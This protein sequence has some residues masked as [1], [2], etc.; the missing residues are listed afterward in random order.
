MKLD[1]SSTAAFTRIDG[2]CD[3]QWLTLTMYYYSD[4]ASGDLQSFPESE[5]R[6]KLW[7]ND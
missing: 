5:M 4:E 1:I 6:A 2:L 7:L 3:Y